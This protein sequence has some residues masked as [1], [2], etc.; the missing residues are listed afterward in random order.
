MIVIGCSGAHKVA[1]KLARHLHAS[2]IKAET[3]FFPDSEVRTRVPTPHKIR[4]KRVLLVQSFFPK[5]NDKILEALF[6]QDTLRRK[7]AKEIFLAAPYFPYLR[8]DKEF[9]PG[10]SVAAKIMPQL[11]SKRRFDTTFIIDPHLHRLKRFEEYFPNAIRFTTT[12]TIA[13]YIRRHIRRPVLIGPDAESF[14][15]DRMIA[16]KIGCPV[17]I[18]HKDRYSSEHVAVK[19]TEPIEQMI[20]GKDIILVDDIIGT[21]HTMYEAIKTIK[22]YSPRSIHCFGVHGLFLDAS[23][24][25]KIQ[26]HATI[27]TTNTVLS[28]TTDIDIAPDFS[29]FLRTYFSEQKK[30]FVK[31]KEQVICHALQ[32]LQKKITKDTILGIGSGTT[33]ERFAKQLGSLQK[34]VTVVSS[35]ERITS[36]LKKYPDITV[37]S[38]TKKKRSKIDIAIDGADE[39]DMNKNIL[40]GQGALAYREEKKI[41]YA[42]TKTYILIDYSKLNTTLTKDILVHVPKSR[43]K[44]LWD[45]LLSHPCWIRRHAH[46][47]YF[48]QCEEQIPYHKLETALAS[49][50]LKNGIF[51]Q[52]RK[53]P[54]I[55]VGY[56]DHVDEI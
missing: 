51:T 16:E 32:K 35:S 10:E 25:R 41:D 18:L 54:T 53:K 34:Q 55:F 4:N 8:E 56:P 43:Q 11:F 20:P 19:S 46:D 7:G 30:G 26:K 50:G 33:M 3:D 24:K 44:D 22:Q 2:Y 12:D 17:T 37:L 48:L 23:V 39:V 49:Y 5:T 13:S 9:H 38:N 36:I 52:F 28:D 1:Q 14:Q 31:E 21:G 42:A 27:H 45:F 47:T 29:Q 40:K 6:I 15:W